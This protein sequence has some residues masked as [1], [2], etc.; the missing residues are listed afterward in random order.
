[1]PVRKP[2]DHAIDMKDTFV[3]KNGRLIPLSPQ[4]QKKVSDF[5]DDPTR[6]GYIRPSKSPQTSPVFFVPKK[7]GKKRMV[8]DYRYLNEHIVKNNY[9]LPPI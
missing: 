3:P 4:E 2:W 6:K 8:Q 9:P 7:D 5:I 1:M